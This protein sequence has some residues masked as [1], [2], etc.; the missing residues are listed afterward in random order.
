MPEDPA[1]G[2]LIEQGFLQPCDTGLRT[3]RRWQAALARAALALQRAG[4]PWDLRLP[5]AAA[6]ADHD[7]ALSDLE[8][9]ELVEAMIPIQEAELDGT[10]P[11]ERAATGVAR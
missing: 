7:P 9:A 11:V 4:A 8:L 1:V 6:L 10:T 3:T 5:I 2:R